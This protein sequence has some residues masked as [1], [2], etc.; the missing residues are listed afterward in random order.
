MYGLKPLSERIP[1]I[2]GQAFSRKF[3]MLGRILTYWTDIVG[4]DLTDFEVLETLTLGD[5]GV[6]GTVC[7]IFEY[8]APATVL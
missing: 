8:R 6:A 4:A 3:V 1:A 7:G 2:A 5:D